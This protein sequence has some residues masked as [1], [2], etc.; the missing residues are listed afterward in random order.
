MMSS[1]CVVLISIE[2]FV[3]VWISKKAKIINTKRNMLTFIG[4]L[5]VLFGTMIGY[6]TSFA[7]NLINGQEHFILYFKTAQTERFLMKNDSS[8]SE[9]EIN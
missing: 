5:F 9:G 1:W 4:T 3:A 6:W 2:R 8:K 7:D